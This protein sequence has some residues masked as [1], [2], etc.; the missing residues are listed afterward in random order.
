[1]DVVEFIFLGQINTHIDDC[2]FLMKL[3]SDLLVH[4][5]FPYLKWT[6]LLSCSLTCKRNYDIYKM[7]FRCHLPQKPILMR[8]LYRHGHL[9]L[10]IYFQETFSYPRFEL[11]DSGSSECV[12]D[13][14]QGEGHVRVCATGCLYLYIHHGRFYC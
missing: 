10:L 8:E 2:C 13:A 11:D 4:H 3:P 1:M 14:I 12:K 7:R 6:S 9:F 5:I